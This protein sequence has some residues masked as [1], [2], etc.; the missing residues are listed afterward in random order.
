MAAINEKPLIL[1]HQIYAEKPARAIAVSV[2]TLRQ[3]LQV[4]CLVEDSPDQ[5]GRTLA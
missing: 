1:A 5:V 2:F 4:T 3:S